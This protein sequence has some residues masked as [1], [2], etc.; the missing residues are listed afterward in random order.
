VIVVDAGTATTIDAMDH[1]GRHL[2]GLILP[3]IAMM[4]RSL[5]SD[6]AIPPYGESRERNLFATDTASGIY[7]AA[8]LSTRC[9]IETMR[10]AMRERV[11]G[12]VVCIMTGG[13]AEALIES[14]PL[15]L[16]HEPHLVLIGLARAAAQ[17]TDS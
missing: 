8:V 2:G 1:R 3:G 11:R 15:R 7:S 16:R 9:T 17:K 12:E 5:S 10:Q 13:A 4:Q 14:A 6:T